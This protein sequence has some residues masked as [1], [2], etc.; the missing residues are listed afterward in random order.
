MN[1]EGGCGGGGGGDGG[2]DS[3]DGGGDG[4][5]G[6][7]GGGGKVTSTFKSK[8]LGLEPVNCC[9]KGRIRNNNKEIDAPPKRPA[10]SPRL[11]DS[12]LNTFP[13]QLRKISR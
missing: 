2:D 9:V 8:F 1:C 3:C 4:G 12:I 10:T 11:F 7:G 5:G 13:I 6:G